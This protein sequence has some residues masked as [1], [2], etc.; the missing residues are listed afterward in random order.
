MHAEQKEPQTL[1]ALAGANSPT[2]EET[3]Q[4]RVWS[5]EVQS[6][7]HAKVCFFSSSVSPLFKETSKCLTHPF[8]DV[9]LILN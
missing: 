4:T 8:F 7:S 6:R 9:H 2:L 5:L 3:T 1:A